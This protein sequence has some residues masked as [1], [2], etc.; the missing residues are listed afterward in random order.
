MSAGRKNN[1]PTKSW[2]T[3]PKIVSAVRSFFGGEIELDPCS[4]ESSLVGAR[5]N[6]ILPKDGLAESWAEYKTVFV[7]PPYG[8]DADRGTSIFHWIKKC[9][10]TKAEIVAL[11]PVATN[12][13]HFGVIFES[14]KSVCFLK[15]SRLKFWMNGREDKKGA[16]MACCLVYWGLEAER[17]VGAFSGMGKCLIIQ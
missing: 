14:A 10:E 11:I 15:D 2:N 17:F 4:N 8:R 12:T 5:E 6:W 3:P 7:N 16:P 9:S 13:K 1:S